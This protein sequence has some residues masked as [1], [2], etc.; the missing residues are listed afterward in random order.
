MFFLGC[1]G[2]LLVDIS[3]Q[4]LGCVIDGESDMVAE[5]KADTGVEV[6]AASADDVELHGRISAEDSGSG[7]DDGR[8]ANFVG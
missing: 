3:V 5:L 7:E 1:N 8:V 4:F 2:G 6:V